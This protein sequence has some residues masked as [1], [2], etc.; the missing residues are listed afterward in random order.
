MTKKQPQYI[1]P[2]KDQPEASLVESKA[3]KG[4]GAVAPINRPENWRAVRREFEE[5]VAEDIARKDSQ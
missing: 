4:Y 3:L 5:L 1:V 2:K